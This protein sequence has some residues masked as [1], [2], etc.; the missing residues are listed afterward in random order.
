MLCFSLLSIS[1]VSLGYS[2]VLKPITNTLIQGYIASNTY[3]SLHSPLSLCAFLPCISLPFPSFIPS[4]PILHHAVKN[5]YHYLPRQLLLPLPLPLHPHC[6][7]HLKFHYHYH[8]LCPYLPRFFS[9]LLSVFALSLSPPSNTYFTLLSLFLS[10]PSISASPSLT[11]L[12]MKLPFHSLY[13]SF[14]PFLIPSFH[15]HPPY[16]SSVIPTTLSHSHF[17]FLSR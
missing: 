7:F 16:Y 13:L 15:S 8:Q 11:S 3:W 12:S 2:F 1:L 9:H 4:K 6:Y 14:S 17:S 5:H 10:S